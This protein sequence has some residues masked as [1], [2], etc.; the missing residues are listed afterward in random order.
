MP[1]PLVSVVMS[2]YNGMP[3]L[4]AA[5]R[6]VLEQEFADLELVLINDGSSDGSGELM[7]RLAAEDSRV[8][9]IEQENQGLAKSL[10]T[11]IA[12]ARGEFIARQDSDDISLPGRLAAQVEVM[13]HD[14]QAAVVGSWYQRIDKDGIVFGEVRHPDRM[15]HLFRLLMLGRAPFPHGSAMIRRS[16][17]DEHGAYNPG[18]RYAQDFEL[19]MRL[20]AAGC[21]LR[22]ASG[23]FYQ[24]RLMP[25]HIDPMSAK[26]ITQRQCRDEVRRAFEERRGANPPASCQLGSENAAA[27][28]APDLNDYYFA[29]G[30]VVGLNGSLKLAQK[31][32]AKSGRPLAGWFITKALAL[33]R[34]LLRRIRPGLFESLDSPRQ[35]N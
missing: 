35:S 30:K 18:F 6:S 29:L 7:H 26:S 17:L 20:V 5:A 8:V 15:D 12:H 1:S 2:V 27:R 9:L 33:G 3:Y 22:L 11:G 21:K 16:V 32:F 34:P 10:N 23:I 24:L 4:E 14:P 19:W 13:R 28:P 31:Y 25:D